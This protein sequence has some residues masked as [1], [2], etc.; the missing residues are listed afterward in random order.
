M[1]QKQ[2]VTE[3][4]LESVI[5]RATSFS[6]PA[7]PLYS[8]LAQFL[9]Q[10]VSLALIWFYGVAPLAR[11]ASDISTFFASARLIHD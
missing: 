11:R 10:N 5:S 3:H 4:L 8:A 1:S 7:F 6:L 9:W 2:S